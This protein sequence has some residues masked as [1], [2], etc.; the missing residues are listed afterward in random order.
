MKH[1]I[2]N[3]FQINETYEKRGLVGALVMATEIKPWGIQGFVSHIVSFDTH[4]RI[5]LRLKWEYIDYVGH[6][7]LV[8]SDK[9]EG[10][11]QE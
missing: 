4:G 1:E 8:P 5:F 7:P 2:G 6:A 9:I 11:T 10:E 3:V